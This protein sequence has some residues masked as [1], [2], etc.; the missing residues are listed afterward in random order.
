MNADDLDA[1][2]NNKINFSCYS[3]SLEIIRWQ[4]WHLWQDF[5]RDFDMFFD[6]INGEID[7]ILSIFFPI[8]SYV[9][10]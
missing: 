4:K 8:A 10:G 3:M 5:E 7:E 6:L 1:N 2:A 9:H